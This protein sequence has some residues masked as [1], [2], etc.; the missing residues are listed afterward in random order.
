MRII[1]AGGGTAGHILPAIVIAEEL[2]KRNVDIYFIVS[3]RGIERDMLIKKGFSFYEQ[4]LR[5]FKR[6]NIANQIISVLLIFVESVKLL[7]IIKKREKILL[8]GGFASLPAG[9]AGTLKRCD[10]Y[11]HE[12]NSSMGL[13][14]KIF[15]P[16]AKKVFLSF[17]NTKNAK[18]KLFY[19]GYPVRQEFKLIN[20]KEKFE[21]RLL[22]LGGS[23]G[24]RKINQLI[25]SSALIL[26]EKGY[27]IAHQTGKK[28]YEETMALYRNEGLS[29]IKLL[30]IFPFY[31]NVASLYNWA[32]IV[33]ARAGAGTIFEILS[34]KRPTIF[35]PL[36]SSADNHQLINAVYASKS[37]FT[38][39]LKEDDAN[40]ES[41]VTLICYIADKY[42]I[43]IKQKLA[44][45]QNLNASEKMM[46]AM[47][48]I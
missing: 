43:E 42:D 25:V 17:E 7:R 3:N 28:L 24:S 5:P 2:K 39:I 31:D 36:K 46:E 23:Q 18:G 35:I 27:H 33:I 15:A 29:N 45:V 20:K 21:K 14:N 16:L 41:L 26:L 47:N 32:D 40:V 6:T 37:G 38:F 11:I 22:V 34:A 4:K 1:F 48:V 13:A 19:T 8:L 10:I 30:N 44:C 9:I 12:Q